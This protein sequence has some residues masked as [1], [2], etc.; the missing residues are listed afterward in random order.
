MSH[1]RTRTAY[2]ELRAEETALREGYRFLD[3]MRLALAAEG[4]RELS[5]YDATREQFEAAWARA[6]AALRVAVVRHG[7]EGPL[8]HPTRPP[9][10]E[11]AVAGRS[12]LGVVLQEGRWSA[13]PSPAPLADTTAELRACGAAWAALL[14][15]LVPLGAA[16]GN[17]TRLKVAYERAARRARA[18]EEVLLPEVAVELRS[19]SD[20]LEEGEREEAVRVREALRLGEGGASAER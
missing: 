1:P 4:V 20:A 3:E 14:P 8:V 9:A 12:R 5:A 2:L 6:V 16:A 17:L 18:L 7:I 10:G 11:V 15:L 19:L 13:G